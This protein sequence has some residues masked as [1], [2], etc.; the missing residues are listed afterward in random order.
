MPHREWIF[1]YDRGKV[2]PFIPLS[3]RYAPLAT[4]AFYVIYGYVK[5]CL[6]LLT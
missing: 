6:E 3:P 4:L 5:T 2:A 1:K